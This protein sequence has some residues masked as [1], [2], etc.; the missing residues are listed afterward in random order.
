M[1]K[2]LYFD[3]FTISKVID[4]S[5]RHCWRLL[6]EL[7]ELELSLAQYTTVDRVHDLF[8]SYTE[9]DIVIV[10]MMINHQHRQEI[11]PL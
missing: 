1:V 6:L 4:F 5:W 10:N 9:L 2:I 8:I 3:Y 11:M 7:A